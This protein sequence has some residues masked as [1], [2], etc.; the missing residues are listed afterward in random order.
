L[1]FGGFWSP[2]PPCGR[3]GVATITRTRRADGSAAATSLSALMLLKQIQRRH[4]EKDMFF[5]EYRR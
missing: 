2:D 4:S 5:L 3:S 1:R